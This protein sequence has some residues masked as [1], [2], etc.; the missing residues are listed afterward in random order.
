M[1]VR[2]AAGVDVLGDGGGAHVGHFPAA[3]D[4]LPLA[5]SHDLETDVLQLFDGG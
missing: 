5:R 1:R 2:A 4:S 3:S